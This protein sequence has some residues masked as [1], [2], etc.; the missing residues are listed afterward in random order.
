MPLTR[1]AAL[2]AALEEA[3]WRGLSRK[4]LDTVVGPHYRR[5]LRELEDRG[6]VLNYR[7]GRYGRGW[8]RVVLV[9]PPPP[10]AESE[11]AGTEVEQIPLLDVDATAPTPA[12]A[13]T[14]DLAA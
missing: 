7:R 10:A 12:S 9:F 3:G 5:R 8:F 11:P 6:A 2:L 14:E 1:C 4:E 13:L